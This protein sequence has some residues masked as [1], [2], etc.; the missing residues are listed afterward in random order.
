M[1]QNDVKKQCMQSEKEIRM[2][3]QTKKGESGIIRG[4]KDEV[5]GGQDHVF[6]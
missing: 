5:R 3:M 4:Q 6:I 2:L 1:T